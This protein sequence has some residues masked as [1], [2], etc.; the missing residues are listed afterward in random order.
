M[1][2]RIRPYLF[3]ILLF[4]CQFSF[5]Q[6]NVDDTELQLIYDKVAN[7]EIAIAQQ[8]FEKLENKGVNELAKKPLY[9]YL[10]GRF[11]YEKENYELTIK[12]F[13]IAR[14]LYTTVHHLEMVARINSNI[15]SSYIETGQFNE[16]KKT[17]TASIAHYKKIG[18]MPQYI[19]DLG[20]LGRVYINAGDYLKAAE[21]YIQTLAYYDA[22]GTIKE[23]GKINAQI[24]LAYDYAGIIDKAEK[25]YLQAIDFRKQIQDT[26]GLINTYNNLGIVNKNQSQYSKAFNYYKTSY[27]LAKA[28][29]KD[30]YKINALIN[31]GVASRHLG[32][33]D[34]AIG[35]Y[36]EAL[37]LAKKYNRQ[38]QIMTIN[39]NLA[40][41]YYYQKKYDLAFP[42]AKSAVAFAE[43][44]GTLEDK[45]NYLQ[46]YAAILKEKNKIDEAYDVL[47][48]SYTYSDSLYRSEN[49]K[50]MTEMSTKYETDKKEQ[51][52]K[53]LHTKAKLQE[54][55]ISNQKLE[56]EKRSLELSNKNFE[57]NNQNLLLRQQENDVKQKSL[58]ANQQKQKIQALN[59]QNEIQVLAIE[60]KNIYLIVTLL[61]LLFLAST[62]YF[63]YNKRKLKARARL[64]EE[65]NKQQDLAARAVLVAEERERRRIAGDLH[66]GVGQMLSAAL[67]N[68]NGMFQKLKLTGE[69]GL[70]AEQTLSIVNDSY[71]EMRSISHQMI[72]N[73]LLKS[74]LAF[75]VKEFL[76]KIDKDMI[77][78]NLE[79]IGL[80]QRL[81]EQTETVLYRVIQESVGNVIKHA[82]ANKLHIVLIRD[83]EGISITIED[84]GKG[85]DKSKT[86][87]RT[88]MGMGNIVSR[89][90]FLK[91]TV[92]ID[93]T[94]GKGTLVAIFIPL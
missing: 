55:D 44:K 75:A 45:V 46:I 67:M 18:N 16:A 69:M 35:F 91:G 94:I 5:A 19:S 13:L 56:L 80:H 61:L 21:I 34:E 76:D 11:A 32:Q 39:N 40:Y 73:A 2:R 58:L 50:A 65:I 78:I 30:T 85:F 86:D 60:Q 79:T 66:D 90:A 74:G 70:Q 7:K 38:S 15:T 14:N 83:E 68:L 82:E 3:F 93:T 20:E 41:L 9:H 81:D 71:D 53:L 37:D 51:Q 12:E 49:A 23:K 52:I 72:P 64:Q 8:L 31:M 92:D 59:Q 47:H 77:K 54:L 62:S 6:K 33:Y 42:L 24:G 27:A 26:V 22:K 36:T 1:L 84:N 89:V 48:K 10:R 43:E 87:L 29:K 25:Y 4:A 17:I 63:I 28:S 57:I 88:G